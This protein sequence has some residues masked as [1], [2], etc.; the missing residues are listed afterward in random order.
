MEPEKSMRWYVA[1]AVI[2][3]WVYSL[4]GPPAVALATGGAAIAVAMALDAQYRWRRRRFSRPSSRDGLD[5]TVRRQW[6]IGSPL[7]L[8]AA[9]PGLL[10]LDWSADPVRLV[11]TIA[12]CTSIAATT[13]YLS[14][15]VDW[16][17][18]LPRVSGVVCL[19]PCE[20]GGEERWTYVTAH[21][22]V[23][24]V[25]AELVVSAAVVAI[26]AAMAASTSGKTQVAWGVGAAAF[27][28]AVSLREKYLLPAIFDAGDPPAKVG[29]VVRVRHEAAER[30]QWDWAY[31]ADV[32]LAGY[33][34]VLLDGTRK[35]RQFAHKADFLLSPTEIRKTRRATTD[36]QAPPCSPDDSGTPACLGVNWYCHQNHLAHRQSIPMP[37]GPRFPT[38]QPGEA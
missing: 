19:G 21:W 36:E 17:W 30:D 37:D 9:L 32:S 20:N 13:V 15:L 35:N 26:P 14:A 5:R 31:V 2:A 11:A 7:M 34:V 22:I 6:A 8:L 18:I 27:T 3:T 33:K 28:A 25:L 1:V 24:R 12:L 38:A 23:H 16:Y 4:W 29:D 10:G